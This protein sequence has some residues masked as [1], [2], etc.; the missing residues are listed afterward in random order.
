MK[1]DGKETLKSGDIVGWFQRNDLH[2]EWGK[3][4]IFHICIK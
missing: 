1:V 3:I 2:F 4:D